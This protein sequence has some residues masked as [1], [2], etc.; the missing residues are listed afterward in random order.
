L[1][2][3]LSPDLDAAAVHDLLLR[4]S[5]VSDGLLLVNAQAAVAALRDA[6]E[7]PR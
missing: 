3:S 2:L 5:R 7:A 4:T 6:R 1:L